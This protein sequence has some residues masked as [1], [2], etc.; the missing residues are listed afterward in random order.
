[1]S[2]ALHVL[3]AALIGAVALCCLP[4]CGSTREAAKA[5]VMADQSLAAA[6]THFERDPMPLDQGPDAMVAWATKAYDRIVVARRL[7][8]PVSGRLS[9]GYAA[10]NL[11]PGTSADQAA[12]DPAGFDAKADAQ[13]KLAADEADAA[14]VWYRLGITALGVLKVAATSAIGIA[15]GGTGAGAAVI[16][17]GA[18]GLAAYREAKAMADEAIT[19]GN[20]V[21][22]EMKRAGGTQARDRLKE[23]QKAAVERQAK[24]GVWQRIDKASKAKRPL[25]PKAQ[26]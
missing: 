20:E 25:E 10:A 22:D 17:L 5:V 26:V 4:G 13:T 3:L 11:D 23:I 6:Q 14:G 2:R 1:V 16:A 8:A 21:T 15:L 12:K 18:K 9:V 24:R 19:Y 7:L